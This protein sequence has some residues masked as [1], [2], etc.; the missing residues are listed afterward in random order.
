M[1]HAKH[2]EHG[3]HGEYGEH[4]EHGKHGEQLATQRQAQRNDMHS[5]RGESMGSVPTMI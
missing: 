5:K 2:G 4:G 1:V 3:K